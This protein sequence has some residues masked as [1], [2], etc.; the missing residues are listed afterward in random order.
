MPEDN[1]KIPRSPDEQ[2]ALCELFVGAETVT[3]TKLHGKIPS[4]VPPP[5]AQAYF[6]HAGQCLGQPVYGSA[7]HLLFEVTGEEPET[8]R[9]GIWVIET[10]VRVPDGAASLLVDPY[11]ILGHLMLQ[12]SF[13]SHPAA[14]ASSLNEWA[15]HQSAYNAEQADNVRRALEKEKWQQFALGVLATMRAVNPSVVSKDVTARVLDEWDTEALGEKRSW[16]TVKR[17]FNGK[18]QGG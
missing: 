12:R 3:A 8:G 5:L 11:R 7:Q 14:P 18:M 2:L 17:F 13:D 4:T 16:E 10:D 6:A 9:A 15:R 1:P